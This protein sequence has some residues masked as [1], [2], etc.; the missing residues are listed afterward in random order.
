MKI[1]V[2]KTE[3]SEV[4]SFRELYRNEAACQIV[5]DSS[6]ARGFTNPY[7]ILTNGRLAGYAAVFTKHYPGRVMEFY[8]FPQCRAYALEMFDALLEAS[9]ATEIEAQTNMVLGSEMLFTFGTNIA[10]ESILFA[11]FVTTDL[12]GPKAG[13]RLREP[14]DKIS[15]GGEPEGDWVLEVDGAVVANGGYLCHYNPPYGDI[16]METSESFRKMGYGSL[17]VQELKRLCYENG[18]KPG[19]RCNPT[20]FASQKTL[21]KAGFRHC[22]FMLAGNIRARSTGT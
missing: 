2:R 14:G 19:A 12:P 8:T 10:A 3:V 1:E 7:L 20:N 17:L 13:F 9:S 22:G 6:I 16:Y 21:E 18:K 11:D 15:N 5:H 4:T